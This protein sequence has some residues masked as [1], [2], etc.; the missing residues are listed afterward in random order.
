[1]KPAAFDYCNPAT[2]GE[3]LSLLSEYGDEGKVLAGGQSLVPLLNF[4]LAHPETL[5]DINRLAE[6]DGIRRRDGRLTIGALTR[7]STV[8]DSAIV[9]EGWPLLHDALGFVAHT[10]IRNRGT[11]GGSVAHADP[12]AEIPVA[13]TALDAVLVARSL[14]GE[15]R[16]PVEDFFFTHLTT[17]LESDELLVA[18]EL[19][20]L[21]PHTGHSFVEFSRRHGD[22]AL[23]GAAILVRL[24]PDGR[25]QGAAVALLGAAPTP[26]RAG[27]AERSLI[28]NDVDQETA[29]A[30]AALAVDSIDPTGDI[31]GSAEYRRGLIETLVR[32][33][34]LEAAERSRNG[35]ERMDEED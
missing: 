6:L 4:R 25:C 8:E 12:S 32:R 29:R 9:A 16:I 15:R 30:A 14:R 19:P 3:A 13:I 2:L 26:L 1:M 5:I 31:H 11:F 7:H 10:Q 24:D 20:A 27:T 35:R 28:G 17:T 18:V 23:G 33:G 21:T 22:F 34:I